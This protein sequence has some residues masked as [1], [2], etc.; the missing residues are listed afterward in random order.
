MNEMLALVEFESLI[1]NS[2]S[3]EIVGEHKS[4]GQIKSRKTETSLS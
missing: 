2:T 4:V 3:A 1:S